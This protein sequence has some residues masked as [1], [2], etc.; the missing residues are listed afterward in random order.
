MGGISDDHLP[1]RALG[2]DI[3]HLIDFKPT[4]GFPSVWHTMDDDAEHLDMDTVEDWGVLMTAFAA[5]WMELEGHI[6]HSSKK[7]VRDEKLESEA[8]R[9]NKKTEL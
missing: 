1:F 4:T 8:I 9:L 6:D 2:V 3:L 7:A 5:E